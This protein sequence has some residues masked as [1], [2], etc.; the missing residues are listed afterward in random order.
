MGGEELIRDVTACTDILT[1]IKMQKKKEDVNDRK[2]LQTN[3]SK[4]N[5][6][7]IPNKTKPPLVLMETSKR[8]TWDS[9]D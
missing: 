1:E 5:L 4:I 6:Y 7:S 9:E 8:H 2:T 3:P